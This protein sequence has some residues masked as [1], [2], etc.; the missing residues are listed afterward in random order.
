MFSDEVSVFTHRGCRFSSFRGPIATCEEIASLSTFL[1]FS[2]PTPPPLPEETY[3]SSFIEVACEGFTLRVDAR[4][5]LQRWDACQR[6]SFDEPSVTAFDWTYQTDYGGSLSRYP[7][8]ATQTTPATLTHPLVD[9]HFWTEYPTGL[10]MK[11][12]KEREP[13]LY[14]AEVILYAGVSFAQ[15][16][17]VRF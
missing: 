12:L 16:R 10:P 11:R 17:E 2:S 15:H 6:R 14:Y 4:G 7:G 9:G 13:I 3:P 1:R 8:Y 5:A